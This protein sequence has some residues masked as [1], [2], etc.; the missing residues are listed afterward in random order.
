MYA[1]PCLVCRKCETWLS[2]LVG[3]KVFY[4]RNF[5]ESTCGS[6]HQSSV[7]IGYQSLRIQGYAYG[8]HGLAQ[9]LT[10]NADD[11]LFTKVKIETSMKLKQSAE[12]L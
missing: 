10:N 7:G 2:S 9:G 3:R 1:M 6:W 11:C 12:C 8:A 4:P 5:G